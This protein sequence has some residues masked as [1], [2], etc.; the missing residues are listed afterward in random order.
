MTER[1]VR[2]RVS[3]PVIVEILTFV[4]MCHTP[5]TLIKIDLLTLLIDFM[6]L[7]KVGGR[8]QFRNNKTTP[9]FAVP[10]CLSQQ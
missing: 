10:G 4:F 5:V 9:G 3:A 1:P 2:P 6:T 7:L 8:G